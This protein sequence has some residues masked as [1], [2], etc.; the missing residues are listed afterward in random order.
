MSAG[1]EDEPALF[2]SARANTA[3]ADA[4]GGEAALAAAP[5]AV[6]DKARCD[7]VLRG[8]WESPPSAG[9]VPRFLGLCAASGVFAVLC[10]FA[11]GALGFGLLAVA[12]G[13]PVVEETAKVILPLMCLEKE[14]WRFR[15][16]FSIVL[17]CFC[18]ALVF[19]TIEN[20]LYFHVYIPKDKLTAGIIRYRL[21]VCTLMH[22]GCTMISVCGLA[23]AWCEAKKN[24]CAFSVQ[25]VTPYLVVAMTAH[26]LYNA[27][28]AIFSLAE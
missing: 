28:A 18:S 17:T 8:L 21:T 13:A 3:G 6:C 15:G 4:I 9:A 20:F 5:E 24:L 10:A 7:M 25:T 11:K 1:I 23:R 16:V 26:G 14:P 12:V 2:D 27:V 19:A 22:V